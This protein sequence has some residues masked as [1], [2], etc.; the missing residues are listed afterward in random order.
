MDKLAEESERKGLKINIK[1]TF[2]MVITKQKEVPKCKILLNGREIEQVT[3]FKYLGSIIT[4]D[5]RSDKDII[6][7][8][9]M[10]KS[11]F[12]EMKQIL[13]NK[14][15]LKETRLRVLRCYVWSVLLYGSE[16]WNISKKIKKKLEAAEM[17]FYRRMLKVPWTDKRTNEEVLQMMEERRTLMT[18]IKLR[19]M[20]FFGHVMRKEGLENLAVTGMVEGKRSRGKQ[21]SKYTDRMREEMGIGNNI[22]L[23][24]N[25]RDREKWKSM[26]ADAAMHGT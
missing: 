10:A 3:Y 2:T 26:A 23:L 21:R 17:W 11:A 6:T 14:K 9:G 20:K 12:M 16:T 18:T 1:K 4:S 15:I 22:E 13:T 8:I 5:G 25:T 19:Q 24:R 7:R